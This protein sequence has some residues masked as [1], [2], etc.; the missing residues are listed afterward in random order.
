M[1]SYL[2]DVFGTGANIFGASAGADTDILVK[3]G[4]LSQDQVDQAGDASLMR[5]L[6]GSAVGYLAQPKNQNYGSAI[7][8]LAKGFQQG[9]EQAK[10]PFASLKSSA[11]TTMK[12]EDYQLKKAERERS[13]QTRRLMDQVRN[14]DG[15]INADVLTQLRATDPKAFLQYQELELNDAKID[16][17]YS[18]ADENR[19]V[20]SMG[21]PIG[22]DA[23]DA[24]DMAK[25]SHHYTPDSFAKFTQTLN[26]NDLV[27][28]SGIKNKAD[29]QKTRM[30]IL[31]TQGQDALD[32][33][34][35]GTVQQ[36]STGAP[37]TPEMVMDDSVGT[38]H[39][40]VNSQ[41]VKVTPII[42]DTSQPMSEIKKYR[43]DQGKV[44]NA[45]QSQ[46]EVL[47][48]ERNLIRKLLNSEGLDR[49]VGKASYLNPLTIRG[50]AGAD[51]EA[52]LYG[53]RQ[54]EF[55]SNYQRIKQAG[56]GFGSLTEKEGDRLEQMASVLDE[57]QSPEQ[58]RYNLMVLDR[59]LAKFEQLDR[60]TFEDIYGKSNYEVMKLNQLPTE[61]ESIFNNKYE[62]MTA[63]QT[64]QPIASDEEVDSILGL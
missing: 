53:I 52:M 51:A 13:A 58:F 10:Q 31:E 23:L 36:T 47:R 25:Y 2:K 19:G 48:R 8:Y 14:P 6:I 5:G 21:N 12:M 45:Y 63:T 1:A 40:F 11:G 35:A 28:M 64:G 15:T 50:E 7:P 22:G 39:D 60:D 9:M 4:L 16:K 38:P 17:L 57:K 37:K 56:G 26:P 32:Q 49:V 18:E 29:I 44:T 20:D 30:E 61:M 43:R 55:I 34:D 27:P 62:N 24:G 41:G 42:Y 33:F 59:E 54:L 3:N 46:S